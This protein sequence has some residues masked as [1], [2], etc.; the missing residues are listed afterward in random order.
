MKI[1]CDSLAAAVHEGTDSFFSEEERNTNAI[2]EE[3]SEKCSLI[4]IACR[5]AD[6]S[7]TKCQAIKIDKRPSL[8]SFGA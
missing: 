5:L 4:G 6:R 3:S 2:I 1:S 8:K 7:Q